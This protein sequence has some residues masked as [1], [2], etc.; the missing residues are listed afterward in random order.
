MG[1][2]AA[3]H[4]AD[5]ADREPWSG[6][7]SSVLEPS[8]SDLDA[9]CRAPDGPAAIIVPLDGSVRLPVD[10]AFATYRLPAPNYTLGDRSG[11]FGWQPTDLHAV[12]P[13]SAERQSGALRGTLPG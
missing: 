11:T 7:S 6:R 9:I 1:R 8:R 13:C 2:L 5:A 10:V 12:V 4:L 3:A